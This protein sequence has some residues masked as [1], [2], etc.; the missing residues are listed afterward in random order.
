MFFGNLTH[1][2]QLAGVRLFSAA[3]SAILCSAT[4]SSGAIVVPLSDVIVLTE[5]FPITGR[6][7]ERAALGAVLL[8]VM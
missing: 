1:C 2:L 7:E 3:I 8:R 5:L 4:R 6:T